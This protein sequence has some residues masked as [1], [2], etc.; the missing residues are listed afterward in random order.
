MDMDQ[1][2]AARALDGAA[3]GLSGERLEGAVVLTH[4]GEDRVGDE[5]GLV[6]LLGQLGQGRIKQERLVVVDDL[7][8]RDLAFAPV[9]LHRLVA[10]AQIGLA[11]L[12]L[13]A[14]MGIGGIGSAG[15]QLRRQTATRSSA[16]VRP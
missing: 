6:A 10:E 13:A 1:A 14:E 2:L 3:G 12:A 5:A 9:L 16:T 8:D 4:H 7:E 11:G 15:Q